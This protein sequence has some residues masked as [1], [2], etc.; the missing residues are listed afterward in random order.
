MSHILIDEHLVL[1]R[2]PKRSH[3]RIC[4]PQDVL[5]FAD[6]R[7]RRNQSALLNDGMLTR[8]R[9]PGTG[10]FAGTGT[11]IV[12]VAG[13]P[14]RRKILVLD[15]ETMQFVASTWSDTTGHY[16]IEG[17]DHTRYY[18]IMALDHLSSGYHPVAYDW[19]QPAKDA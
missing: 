11:G 14:A 4:L 15:R 17:L 19:L 2:P 5:M 16:R 12:T 9:C 1:T 6:K 18:L 8:G 13:V 7:K 10:Y 3:Q